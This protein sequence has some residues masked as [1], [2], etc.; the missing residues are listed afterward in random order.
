MPKVSSILSRKSRDFFSMQKGA[1]VYKALEL[2]AEKNI[3]SLVIM[4]GD[5]YVGVMTERDYSRKVILKNKHSSDTMVD[6]IMST[7]FPIVSPNDTIDHCM[8]L[9]SEKNIRYL[10]VFDNDSI[11]GVVSI[12]DVVGETIRQQGETINHLKDYIHGQ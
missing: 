7:D 12:G 1:T 4:D 8:A 3:G 9:M 11:I 10:P 6:E 2:M 5:K